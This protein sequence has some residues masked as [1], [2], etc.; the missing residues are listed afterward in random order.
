MLGF[1]FQSFH[2]LPRLTAWENVALPLL[3][4]GT[5]RDERRPKA[6]AMLQQVGLAD[7]AQQRPTNSR[8]ASSSASLSPAR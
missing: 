8:A 3:Y 7:F 1:V 5:P 4:G 2:L 6:L